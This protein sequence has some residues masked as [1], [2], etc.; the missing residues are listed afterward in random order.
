MAD[1]VKLNWGTTTAFTTFT[2]NSVGD[3]S[4][5]TSDGVDLGAQAPAQVGVHAVLD[6]SAA[7][8]SADVEWYALW[9]EDDVAYTAAAVA[10]LVHT[11][12]MQGTTAFDDH[13]VFDVK[14][15]YFQMHFVNNSGASMATTGNSAEYFTIA[16]DQA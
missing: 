5:V 15:R 10:K 11:S 3:G 8:N 12:T 14:A 2:I 13:F 1:D 7:G 16:V 4:S 6:G 9:S